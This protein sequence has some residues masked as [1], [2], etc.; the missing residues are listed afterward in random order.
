M[1]RGLLVSVLLTL[2]VCFGAL[3]AVV[4]LGW[5]PLL[6][7]DLRGGLE[8][9]YCPTKRGTAAQCAPKTKQS[10]LNQVVSILTNR[11][12]SLGVSQPN[13]GVQGSD[14]VVQLPGV[15]NPSRVE[16]IIGQTAQLY[17]RPVLCYAAP[18]TA[19]AKHAK[20][21]SGSSTTTTSAAGS[22]T[23][24]TSAG[25]TTT[26]TSAGSTTTTSKAGSTTTTTNPGAASSAA[27][28]GYVAPPACPAG[29]QPTATS[30]GA[31]VQSFATY[32]TTKPQQDLPNRTIVLPGPTP[33]GGGTRWVLGP[34][35]ANGTI[36]S[37]AFAQT[38]AG[39]GWAIIFNLTAKGTT[40]FNSK[41]AVP[42]YHKLIANDLDGKVESAPSINSTNFPGSGQITG[43]FTSQSANA[44]ALVLNYGAL[45]VGLNQLTKQIVS[46]TLGSASLR[47]GLLAGLLG[48][49]LVMAYTIFYYRALGIVVVLGLV[50]TAA[51]I[52]A[53]ISGLGHTSAALTLDLSG[54]TGLIVSVGITVDSYVVYFERLKDEVRA[55]RSIRSSV[56]R[57]F[58]S[59]YR[60][61]LSADA[62]SFIGAFVLWLLSVGAVRGFAF[63]LGLSTLIDVATAYFFTRPLVILLGRNRLFTEAR[64]LGV[65]RGLAAPAVEG[66]Q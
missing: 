53:I 34:A 37:S 46:P 44:L 45:P 28:D 23:T 55:G 64:G 41:I 22:T 57:G 40:T 29:T 56:D 59:A 39:T 8:V 7:L 6:G 36:I 58:R 62:V 16:S 61:I 33:F 2:V 35:V 50:S 27:S 38:Q 65:A 42:Y 20:P 21:A 17:F 63:M 66:Q 13:I 47:A 26:T 19:P 31:V 11:V 51:L 24:T 25:S 9:V 12:N 43:N 10:T 5:K 48:L 15:K 32:P 18:Y 1:K 52:Y 14:I 3:A 60:T 49:L 54:I 4:G 30:N